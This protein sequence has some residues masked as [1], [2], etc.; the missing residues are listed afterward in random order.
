MEKK[1]RNWLKT[2]R[3]YEE[4]WLRIQKNIRKDKKRHDGY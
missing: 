4:A 3:M 2:L 1:N